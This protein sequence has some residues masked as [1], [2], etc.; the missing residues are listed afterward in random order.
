MT[1]LEGKPSSRLHCKRGISEWVERI[2]LGSFNGI[3][4]H[5]MVFSATIPTFRVQWR[6]IA[7]L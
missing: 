5:V 2:L 3:T 1:H 4:Q 7:A 6:L